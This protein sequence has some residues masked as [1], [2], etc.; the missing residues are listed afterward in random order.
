MR[1]TQETM[2]AGESDRNDGGG[3]V[4]NQKRSQGGRNL[5]GRLPTSDIAFLLP[6]LVVITEP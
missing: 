1:S 4:H 6:F 2:P 3:S 5:A